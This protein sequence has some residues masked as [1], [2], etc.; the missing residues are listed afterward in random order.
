M[1][2]RAQ[3]FVHVA[4]VLYLWRTTDQLGHNSD[5][6]ERIERRATV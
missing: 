6:S 2:L 5:M 1:T 4:I 3:I